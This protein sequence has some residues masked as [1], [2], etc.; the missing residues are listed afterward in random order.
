VQERDDGHSNVIAVAGEI[1]LVTAPVL[2]AALTR[3]LEPVGPGPVVVLDMSRVAY[4]AATGIS[5]L[6]QANALASEHKRRL[7]LVVDR[8]SP[9]VTRPLGATGT[10]DLIDTY[11]DLNNA[12]DSGSRTSA[13]APGQQHRPTLP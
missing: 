7:R 5:T 2:G 1:D 4:I 3:A 9:A 12:A 6:I 13:G 11:D 8:A 10:L